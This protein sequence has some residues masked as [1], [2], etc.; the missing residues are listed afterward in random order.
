MVVGRWTAPGSLECHFP[1]AT[2]I[3]PGLAPHQTGDGGHGEGH[4]EKRVNSFSYLGHEFGREVR[5]TTAVILQGKR[6][7]TF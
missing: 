7:D 5:G 6:K 1:T 4:K 2:S 3:Q